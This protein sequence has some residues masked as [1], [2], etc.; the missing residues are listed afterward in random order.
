VI[1]I[2]YINTEKIVSEK[3][4]FGVENYFKL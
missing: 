4:F 1:S 2:P 3:Y